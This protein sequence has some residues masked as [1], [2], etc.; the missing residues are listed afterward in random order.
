MTRGSAKRRALTR[1]ASTAENSEGHWLSTSP[2]RS[3]F[4]HWPEAASLTWTAKT[5]AWSPASSSGFPGTSVDGVDE[6]EPLAGARFLGPHR[7]TAHP[8][9]LVQHAL[10]DQVCLQRQV[11]QAQQK[12]FGNSL[13]RR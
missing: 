8:D 13:I 9:V 12:R 2:L 1:P 5:R 11:G 10:P 3:T 4:H 6:A 7:R